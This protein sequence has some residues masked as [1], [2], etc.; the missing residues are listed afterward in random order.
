MPSIEDMR[1]EFKGQTP[2]MLAM[3]GS[4][5]FKLFMKWLDYQTQ[6]KKEKLVASQDADE[7]LFNRTEYTG[8]LNMQ[9]LHL[10]FLEDIKRIDSEPAPTDNP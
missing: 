6:F 9:Q 4:D 1:Q 5:G 3:I 8:Y 2:A 10:I 7:W